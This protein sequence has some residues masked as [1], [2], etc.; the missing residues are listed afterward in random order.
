MKHLNF[1]LLVT[2]TIFFFSCK[3]D[4]KDVQPSYQATPIPDK[5]TDLII[6]KGNEKSEIVYLYS[7]GGPTFKLDSEDLDEMV[8]DINALK[9]YVHQVQTLSPQLKNKKLNLEQALKE[10]E[11]SIDILH[12][13]ITHYKSLKKKVVVISHSFGS[14][15]TPY[16]LE[17]YGN[18]ADAM[19]I[20]AG[21]I[22]MPDIVWKA[23]RDGKVMVFKDGKTPILA[24]KKDIDDDAFDNNTS[25]ILAA[26]LGQKRFSKILAKKDLDKVMYVFSG[27]DRAVGTLSANE[28]GFLI[29]K[30]VK[31]IGYPDGDHG[32]MFDKENAK[33]I[34]Q[35]INELLVRK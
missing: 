21:R 25:K 35:T 5:I 33:N 11:V 26:S 28:R 18:E 1:F 7:Q 19:C 9:V 27:K 34:M 30:K 3:D 4:S 32:A 10:N 31:I 8:T 14:F 12:K 17:K 13:V 20:M 23:F 16:Y 29:D 24:S 15:I 6:T 2:L 22:D